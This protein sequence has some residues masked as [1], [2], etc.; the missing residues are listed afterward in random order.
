[1]GKKEGLTKRGLRDEYREHAIQE[2]GY[3][4]RTIEKLKKQ[5]ENLHSILDFYSNKVTEKEEREKIKE[6][7][8]KVDRTTIQLI[9]LK[10]D[11]EF[12]IIPDIKRETHRVQK[13]KIDKEKAL[14]IEEKIKETSEEMKELSQEVLKFIKDLK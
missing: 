8:A 9:E 5:G 13:G 1:M 10:L 6:I 4:G 12:K 3:S 7:T 2:I 11:Y 14:K